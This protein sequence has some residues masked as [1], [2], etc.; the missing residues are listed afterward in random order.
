MSRYRC[1]ECGR[2]ETGETDCLKHALKYGH[3]EFYDLEKVGD[4][5]PLPGVFWTPKYYPLDDPDILDE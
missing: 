3:K 4:E 5:T 1:V 2:E